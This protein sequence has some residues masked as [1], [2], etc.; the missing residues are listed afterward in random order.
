M[1]DHIPTRSEAEPRTKLQPARL[2]ASRILYVSEDVLVASWRALRVTAELSAEA[3]VFWATPAPLYSSPVQVV[4]SVLVPRQRVSGGRYEVPADAVREMGRKLRAH[5]LV[6]VAQ[7]HTHPSDWVS[8]S[9][10]DDAHAFSLRDGALSIVWPRYAR[11]LPSFRSWGVHECRA[12]Q[13]IQLGSAVAVNR[14]RIL[15]PVI[16]LRTSLEWIF[17]AE[18]QEDQV[19]TTRDGNGDE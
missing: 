8:H 17:D 16:D 19:K 9:S 15:P 7:L 1:T 13:W 3:V 18:G 12:R 11:E 4:T 6:N 10:W 2:A 14:I 5:G